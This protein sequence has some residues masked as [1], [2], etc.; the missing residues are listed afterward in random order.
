MAKLDLRKLAKKAVK[1]A[2][3][4]KPA[5]KQAGSTVIW[6]KTYNQAKSFKGFKRIR[7]TTYKERDVDATLSYF[8]GRNY[9]FTNSAIQF[10]YVRVMNGS[11]IGGFSVVNVYADAKRIGCIYDTNYDNFDL[12]T[13]E[14][15]D[16]AYLRVDNGDVYLF[17][18]YN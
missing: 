11:V 8:A 1:D 15:I 17:V 5:A 16:S 4:S 13:K 6:T 12:L 3:K 7:L 2:A 9:D 10:Q 14:N 18:H